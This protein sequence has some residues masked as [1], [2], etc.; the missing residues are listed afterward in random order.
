MENKI[1]KCSIEWLNK[2]P[3]YRLMKV[4]YIISSILLIAS[5]II[6]SITMW[7]GL[8]QENVVN[9]DESQLICNYGNKKRFSLKDLSITEDLLK[10]VK[11]DDPDAYLN[12]TNQFEDK[13][14]VN[15]KDNGV[16]AQYHSHFENSGDGINLDIGLLNYVNNHSVE[17]IF[18]FQSP[19]GFQ[20]DNQML[21]QVDLV[22]KVI[23][24][25]VV[26]FFYSVFSLA[27]INILLI[28][29]IRRACYYILLGKCYPDKS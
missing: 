27:I 10:S 12:I 21:F 1:S 16:P 5:S 3:W 23:H 6:F 17:S 22:Y 15:W 19:N 8:I 26:P 18:N 11:N 29:G 13:C 24:V 20:A 14:H 2:N 25:G 28:E 9:M 7:N 4:F